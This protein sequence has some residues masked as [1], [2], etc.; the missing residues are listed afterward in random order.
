[1]WCFDIILRDKVNKLIIRMGESRKINPELSV[2]NEKN[3]LK[4]I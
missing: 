2:V 1:M 3:E 4:K